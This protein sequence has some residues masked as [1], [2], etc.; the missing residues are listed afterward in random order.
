MDDS[1]LECGLSDSEMLDDASEEAWYAS[2]SPL[3]VVHVVDGDAS[4]GHI[5]RIQPATSVDNPDQ[6]QPSTGPGRL[7]GDADSPASPHVDTP[8]RLAR[9]SE[10]DV[11]KDE[12]GNRLN[13]LAKIESIFEAMVD[14]LLNERGQLCVAIKPRPRERGQPHDPINAAQTHVESV[15]HLCFPGKT[16]KEAWRFGERLFNHHSDDT[17]LTLYSCRDSYT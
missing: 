6:C 1:E 2:A 17:A 3:Q 11:S 5:H 12:V 9:A 7:C 14:V 13:V 8:A 4:S 10:Q 15:Q 16:E